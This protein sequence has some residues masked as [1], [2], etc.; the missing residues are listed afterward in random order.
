VV[1]SSLPE[2]LAYI[3]DL[4][5]RAIDLGLDRVRRVAAAMDFRG[6]PC[7]V[8]TVAGTNGKGSSV[9]MLESVLS[10]AGYRVAVYTSPHLLR[11]NERVRIGGREADDAS[12]CA[13]FERVERARRDET[14]TYFEFG[15]LAALDLF[16]RAR[17]DVAVL[18]VG[19]GGRLDAVNL[20]DADVALIT[21]IGLDHREWLGAD[22][23]AIAGEK[24]GIMRRG[25]PAVCSDPDPPRGLLAA[26]D[27]LGVRIACLGSDFGWT[28]DDAHGLWSWHGGAS[29]LGSLPRPALSGR[30][31]LDNAA[32]VLMALELLSHRLPVR[33]E[34]V[35]RG[36][37]SVSLPG[38]F[39]A[40]S[41]PVTRIF[42]VA[43]NLESARALAGMLSDR[44]IEGATRA[45][46][47]ILADKDIDGMIDAVAGCVD[48][49]Y[50][51]ALPV[52]RA[53]PVERIMSAIT[54]RARGG[55]A[56]QHIDVTTAYRAALDDASSGDRIIVFGSFHT[57]GEALRWELDQSSRA[58]IP[59]KIFQP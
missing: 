47:G 2:W 37:G 9:A 44:P 20:V 24:A 27:R 49:W 31:Q 12:L 25:R 38:R 18:E 19:M 1:A 13:A 6:L 59:A 43:H 22:R 42:D 16:A 51:A 15:T 53:A 11:Y 40:L 55:P 21:M 45:V 30:F 36:L 10:A 26:G 58:H 33:D 28:L 41:G 48:A 14:L 32:G 35:A 4:H 23:D 54:R 29:R 56:S 7:P 3:E 39:Q 34:A 17:P 5:P 46:V 57:V 52:V 50:V 8:I